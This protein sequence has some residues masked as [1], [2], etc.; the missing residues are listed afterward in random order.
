MGQKIIVTESQ[1]RDMVVKAINEQLGESEDEAINTKNLGKSLRSGWSTLKNHMSG[2]NESKPFKRFIGGVKAGVENSRN[3]NEWH[4]LEDLRAQIKDVCQ[5]YNINQEMPIR[6]LIA[7][8]GPLG[9]QKANL[10]RSI[11]ANGGQRFEESINA[12]VDKVINEMLQK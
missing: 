7:P 5:K 8:A 9:V 3:N 6:Q 12:V 10:T 11:T 1:L 4:N 2:D